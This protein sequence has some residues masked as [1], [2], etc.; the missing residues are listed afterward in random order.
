MKD[1]FDYPLNQYSLIVF[2]GALGGLVYRLN[3]IANNKSEIH[4]WRCLLLG[5][6]SD[7]L[8]SGFVAV[9]MFWVCAILNIDLL[10]SIVLSGMAGHMG[11]RL[12]FIAESLLVMKIS[13]T[14][15]RD[16]K[17]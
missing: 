9:L 16:E 15:K 6:L 10:A 11:A 3:H 5:I 7:L 17:P 4:C 8:T 13:A 14:V 12:L 2:I 1:P